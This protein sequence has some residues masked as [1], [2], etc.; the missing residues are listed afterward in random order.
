MHCAIAQAE[1]EDMSRDI[2][3]GIKRGFQ[4]GRSGYADFVCFGYKRD[5]DGKL[6]ID[7]PDVRIVRKIFL[8]V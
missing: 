3:W 1:S 4:S 6:A 8:V 2:K 5:D 7:E